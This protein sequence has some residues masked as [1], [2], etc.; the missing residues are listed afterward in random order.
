MVLVRE[1]F[2]DSDSRSTNQEI[3]WLLMLFCLF[4]FKFLQEEFVFY[5]TNMFLPV[6]QR[7]PTLGPKVAVTLGEA[8]LGD[9]G[10]F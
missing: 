6:N 8:T 4:V 1:H 7:R 3:S 2:S 10:R 5:Y 9:F